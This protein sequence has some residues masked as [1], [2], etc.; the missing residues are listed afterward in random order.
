MQPTHEIL[1]T[2][3]ANNVLQ[4]HNDNYFMNEKGELKSKYYKAVHKLHK[5]KIID[6]NAEFNYNTNEWQFYWTYI[7]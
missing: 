7:A 3:D 6:I 5:D 4:F 2:K 1:T